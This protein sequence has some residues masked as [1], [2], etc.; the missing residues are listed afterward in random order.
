[1]SEFLF[2][3][4]T[5]ANISLETSTTW[6]TLETYQVFAAGENQNMATKYTPTFGLMTESILDSDCSNNYLRWK[7]I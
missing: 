1:M 5:A 7:G 3:Q 6:L 2:S 4:H